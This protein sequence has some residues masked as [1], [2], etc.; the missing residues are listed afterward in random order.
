[1]ADAAASLQAAIVDVLI[2]KAMKA[3]DELDAPA[4]CLVGGVAANRPLREGLRK[5]CSARGIPFATPDFAL[6]TDN[7]AMIGL[8]ATFRLA[9][10][11]RDGFDLDVIASSP[12]PSA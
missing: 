9:A 8:A 3:V 7:A 4:L 2:E 12:L 1:R 11:E 10:G 6:C 5:A